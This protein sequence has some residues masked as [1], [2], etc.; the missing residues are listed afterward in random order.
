MGHKNQQKHSLLH[1]FKL[2][3]QDLERFGRKKHQDKADGSYTQYIY[4]FST[5]R[6]YMQACA[7]FAR[8]CKDNHSCRTIAD[9]R[10]YVDQYLAMRIDTC[11]AYTVKRD[12]AALAKVYGVT[13]QKIFMKTPSRQRKDISRSRGKA[14]RDAHFSVQ[15]NS[16]LISFLRSTGLRRHEAESLR[17]TQLESIR[18]QYFIRIQGTQAKGGR[19]RLV[20]VIG[21]VDT[22]VRLMMAAGKE[23]VFGKIHS[24][25]DVHSYRAE[26]AAAMY[27]AYARPYREC[28]K[29]KV[30]DPEA[31]KWRSSSVYRCRGE[32]K[33]EWY[34]IQ[35]MLIVS[36]AL[37][38]NRIS[39]IAGHYLHRINT[40]WTH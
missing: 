1:Q 13:G 17:G 34:D 5:A 27:M 8:W 2:S 28:M 33:G 22:V 35:A 11:S 21:E 4:S 3:L 18:G 10:Q 24:A 40:G 29:S 7:G 16:D 32:R 6:A 36:R 30:W 15:R 9:C 31:G 20:P 39:I 19:P 38:H 25:C 26:Y 23:K 12:A 37:G 14:I